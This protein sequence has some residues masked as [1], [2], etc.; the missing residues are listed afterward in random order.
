LKAAVDYGFKNRKI[1]DNQSYKD[2]KAKLV[3]EKSSKRES[4]K[5]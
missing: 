4:I 2:L 1:K 5:E 3:E